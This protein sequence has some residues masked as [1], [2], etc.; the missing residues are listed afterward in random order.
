MHKN[1]HKIWHKK[2]PFHSSADWQY[3]LLSFK[4][5]FKIYNNN[6]VLDYIEILVAGRSKSTIVDTVVQAIAIWNAF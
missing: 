4:F 2:A 5:K 3:I 6:W 1:Q